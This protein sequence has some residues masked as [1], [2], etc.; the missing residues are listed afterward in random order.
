MLFRSH[1]VTPNQVMLGDP[2]TYTLYVPVQEGRA[3]VSIPDAASLV[4][5]E[6]LSFQKQ[7]TQEGASRVT[8]LT[9]KMRAFEL[10]ELVIPSQNIAYLEDGKTQSQTLPALIVQVQDSLPSDAQTYRDI[11]APSHRVLDKMKLFF[12]ILGLAITAVVLVYLIR[13]VLRKKISPSF[14]A[15]VDT[16]SPLEISLAEL[17]ELKIRPCTS[18]QDYKRF[19]LD[20]SHIMKVYFSSVLSLS[21]CEMTSEEL[22][23]QLRTTLD[24]QSLRRLN[25]IMSLSDLVKFAKHSPSAE[26]HGEVI[27]KAQSCLRKIDSRFMTRGSV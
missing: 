19:Y 20:L 26:Q 16:R 13:R 1:S 11:L 2:L 27:E 7:Q 4:P 24:E 14:N 3:L 25:K 23:F 15:P 17:A 8:R 10:G 6:V 22:L 9:Y 12:V 5:F 21:C 18:A